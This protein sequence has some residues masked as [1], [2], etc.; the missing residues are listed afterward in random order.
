MIFLCLAA[1]H[2]NMQSV[3]DANDDRRLFKQLQ[4]IKNTYEKHGCPS[5]EK[6]PMGDTPAAFQEFGTELKRVFEA[7]PLAPYKL[8]HPA[9]YG[10]TKLYY[11]AVNDMKKTASN[12]FYKVEKIA[13]WGLK[14]LDRLMGYAQP[15][16]LDEASQKGSKKE[17]PKAE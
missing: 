4:F 3:Y 5:A 15:P 1:M 14:A 6:K 10:Q 12:S 17:A 13:T 8:L 16:V 11:R 2:A 7:A 9:S